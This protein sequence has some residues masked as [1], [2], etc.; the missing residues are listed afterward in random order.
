M[1]SF[2]LPV[3]FFPFLACAA[4]T[5]LGVFIFSRHGD[6]TAKSTP[7][8]ALTTLGYRQIFNSGTYFRNRYIA[9]NVASRIVGVD[10]DVVEQSQITVSAPVDTVLMNS[11]QEFLQGLYPPVGFTLASDTL[12]NGSVIS[13]PLDG[14][15]LIPIR[16]TTAGMGSEDSAWL[17]ASG[18]CPQAILSSNEY[19]TS[20]DYNNLLASTG[21]FYESLTPLI[22]ATF[23]AD[24][25][26]YKNAYTIFD[27]LNVASIHNKSLSA[28]PLLTDS[29]FSQLRTLAD[30]HELNLAYN[31]TDPVRAIA[32][33]TLAA[34]IVQGLGNT[35]KSQ[36]KSKITVEFGAYASFQSFFGLADLLTLPD[37]NDS[38]MGI[39]DYASTMTF[40]LFTTA[41]ASSF[42]AVEDLQVRFLFHNGT[43]D[44]NSRLTAYPLF[45]QSSTELSWTEFEAG[46]GRFAVGGQK[47]WCEACGNSTGVC[48]SATG[49]SSSS[50]A[51]AAGSGSGTG[52]G[53]SKAAAG[54]IGAMVT[55]AVVLGS[56]AAVM[57][58]AGLRVVRKNRLAS[59][60]AHENGVGE[61]DERKG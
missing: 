10:S 52:G 1:L 58:V 13:P 59:R 7:P 60:A 38:F 36:G 5:I 26:S 43:M 49:S 6:R 51:G 33:S 25:I 29:V 12:R 3:L 39:P 37:S 32:G 44:E 9:P 61:A 40:E 8:T 16:S 11:A 28:L 27:L 22:N 17:Q 56:Q 53:I 34:Q 18:N 55:L 23:G 45:G 57:L 47:Q 42:P 50:S 2:L 19:F 14:Y 4:E 35:I 30:H 46:M 15:Q 21:A 31:S 41:D 20:S 48:A 54:V 24:Q